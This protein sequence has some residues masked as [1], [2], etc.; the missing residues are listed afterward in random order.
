M[1]QRCAPQ[2]RIRPIA[3]LV[4]QSSRPSLVRTFFPWSA[5]QTRPHSPRHYPQIAALMMATR[6]VV[7]GMEQ[8]VQDATDR[9]IPG[10]VFSFSHSELT[11][12]IVCVVAC[13][14]AHSKIVDRSDLHPNHSWKLLVQDLDAPDRLIPGLVFFVCPLGTDSQDCVLL[15]YL[16]FA[17][18]LFMQTCIPTTPG[19]FQKR[20]VN[21]LC[22][23][24][25][26]LYLHALVLNSLY[27]F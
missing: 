13:S 16:V 9:L 27:D 22:G 23:D 10:L 7:F 20:F 24:C 19:N 17:Q 6:I 12:K 3:V 5:Q 4:D 15:L 18:M 25:A 26:L 1:K 21:A 2:L 11:P 14:I 8:L